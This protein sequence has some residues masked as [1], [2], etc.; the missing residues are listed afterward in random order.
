MAKL[1][2]KQD[3]GN[4]GKMS[5]QKTLIIF[6]ICLLTLSTCGIDEIYYLPQVSEG[7]ISRNLN[8]DASIDTSSISLPYYATGFVI[9]YKIYICQ[10]NN[11]LLGSLLNARII[12][13]YNYLSPYT[14]PAKPSSIPSLATF[15]SRGFYELKLEGPLDIGSTISGTSFDIKFP[16]G[17]GEYPHIN[18]NNL[19]RSNSGFTPEP[20]RYF[21]S[22]D[23]LNDYTNAVPAKNA[24]VSAVSGESENAYAS[25]YI[26]AVGQDPTNFSRL[27]GKPTHINIFKLPWSN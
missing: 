11:E 14:D 10:Q 13:D 20:D 25:M 3:C 9:Y 1:G 24:D 7:S 27:Y 21:R 16:T 15:S 6:L 22:S 8:T 17:T 5:R 4:R 19:L 26:V 23:K 18:N 12:S 2:A